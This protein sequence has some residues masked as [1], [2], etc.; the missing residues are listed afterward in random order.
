M[1][2]RARAQRLRG[3]NASQV[4]LHNRS[5]V[6]RALLRHG[7]LSR[8]ALAQ[9]TGLMPS[10]ITYA[11][12]QLGAAHLVADVGKDSSVTNAAG[13]RQ[14]VLVDVRTDGVLALAVHV[15][16]ISL[17]V[18]LVNLK[19]GVECVE[20]APLARGTLPE[21]VVRLTQQLAGRLLARVE[22]SRIVGAGIA[23]VGLV[24]PATGN[25]EYAAYHNW[26]DVPLA[27]LLA[28][29]LGLPARLQNATRALALAE[30]WYGAGRGVDDL[31]AIVVTEGVGAGII[32]GG[33][34]YPGWAGMAGEIGHTVVIEHGPLC[35]CGKR[36]CL[37]AVA[38][39]QA[40]ARHTREI[41]GD[42][43]ATD[44][45]AGLAD[46][47]A[48]A[49]AARVLDAAGAGQPEA[50]AIVGDALHHLALAVANLTVVID[51][52]LVILGG[53]LRP[54]RDLVVR[55]IAAAIDEVSLL[56]AQRHPQVVYTTLEGDPGLIGAATLAFEA[57]LEHGDLL[58]AADDGS[59]EAVGGRR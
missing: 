42:E 13:G 8:H 49:I 19:G 25:I 43:H 7:P 21:E 12:A 24:N 39:T 16:E 27:T 33:E 15:A 14:P 57:F 53:A 3:S 54:V 18:G 51:P 9:L 4:K 48:P 29:A 58:T 23:A 59:F 56:P 20:M 6:I 36:G 34:M 10:T 31:I 26:H 17:R 44:L 37:E 50:L 46:D 22:R 41:A 5:I 45:F 1:P 11:V 55:L 30:H 35:A 38:S 40:I 52:Q 47:D 2:F 28:S 32:I